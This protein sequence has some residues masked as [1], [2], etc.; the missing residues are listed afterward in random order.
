MKCTEFNKMETGT[1]YNTYEDEQYDLLLAGVETSLEVHAAN[2]EPL[3]YTD[4]KDLYE[5][6]LNAI[7]EESRQT[8]KCNTCRHFVNTYGGLVTID[9]N[10]ELYPI[11]WENVPAFFEK[12]AQQ[13]RR[14]IKCANV[15]GYFVTDEERLGVTEK[16]GFH[17]LSAKVPSKLIYKG[18]NTLRGVAAEKEEDYQLLTN[19]V[20]T[21][22]L[23]DARQA[24][25]LV[26]GDQ[27]RKNESLIAHAKW[28]FDVMNEVENVKNQ[29]TKSHILW[30]NA[31]KAPA[32]LCHMTT[33]KLATVLALIK[34]GK[35]QTFIR[36]MINDM[37]D[38]RTDQRKQALPT[39]G[40]KRRAE[41][42]IKERGLEN[43]FKRRFARKE[44]IKSVWSPIEKDDTMKEGFFAKVRT[45]ESTKQNKKPV[46]EDAMKMT[47]K[48]FQE[49]VLPEAEKIE[50]AVRS[51]R[52]N[53]SA[54]ITAV[55][56]DAPPIIQWDLEEERNPFN[57]Y[58]YING[59]EPE[60]WGLRPGWVNVTKVA[61]QP[62]LWHGNFEHEGK[63]VFF[64]LEG[65]KDS[66][67]KNIALF[68]GILK[69]H[70]REIAPT[71]EEH[72]KT[73]SLDGYKEASACGLR[74]QDGN[75]WNARF[76]V[77]TKYEIREY[78]LD[79]WD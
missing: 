25:Q 41:Q 71:I 61:L 2:G 56:L 30:L 45:K 52:D 24:M 37:T 19:A 32:G 62:N 23:L 66:A 38:P 50:Y 59:S 67:N 69:S 21:Y 55:D 68:P 57:W 42:I 64:L 14:N 1:N 70:L 15:T 5:Y 13:V 28:F 6:F 77:E 39:E 35:N 74:L 27:V 29:K 72:I 79:R 4:A 26:Q 16:G 44:E 75:N 34:E 73:E 33:T 7:P 48:K 54:L 3:F 65:A 63:A 60:Q 20:E 18:Y 17:H 31:V 76:R 78:I 43:S 51:C 22:S 10:G 11:M 53:F 47:W 36:R 40:N 46:I 9:E 8:Y 12:A 58:V 49:T